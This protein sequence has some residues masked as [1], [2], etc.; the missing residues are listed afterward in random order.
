M[1]QASALRQVS[2]ADITLIALMTDGVDDPFHPLEQSGVALVSQWPWARYPRWF[3]VTQE[4]SAMQRFFLLP[5][6]ASPRDARTGVVRHV[7][8]GLCAAAVMVAL[9]ACATV[10]QDEVGVTR[11][12]GRVS[13]KSSSPGG[14][15]IIPG[16]SSVIRVPA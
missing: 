8:S 6:T 9:S 11:T 10:H 15:F 7:T 5:V 4:S 16:F 14:Q 1:T 2:A 3:S 12:L 13:Q